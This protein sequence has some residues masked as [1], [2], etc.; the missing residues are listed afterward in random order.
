MWLKEIIWIDKFKSKIEK[1]HKVAIEEVEDVLFEGAIFRRTN[2]G[3]VKGEDVY[4][5]YG[6]T[7]AG[8]YLFIVF[9]YKLSMTGLVVSAR[10]MTDKERKYYHAKKT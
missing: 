6:R 1:K 8:R 9:I 10:D 5:G 2:R 3:R 7:R 4:L